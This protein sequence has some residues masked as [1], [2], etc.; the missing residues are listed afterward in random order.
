MRWR[1]THRDAAGRRHQL[2]LHHCSR[3]AAQALAEA[4]YGPALYLA[5]IC[6]S[7]RDA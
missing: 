7:R 3:L 6:L 5:L 1:V 4:M 2:E